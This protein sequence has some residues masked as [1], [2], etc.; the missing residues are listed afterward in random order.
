MKPCLTAHAGSFRPPLRSLT[1]VQVELL[2]EVFDVN[3]VGTCIYV[4]AS[5]SLNMY[6]YAF[7]IAINIRQSRED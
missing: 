5:I 2:K 6:V 1:Y 4:L 7:G 3:L